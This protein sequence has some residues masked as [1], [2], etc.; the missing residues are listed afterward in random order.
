[1]ANYNGW[2]N[3][4]TWCVA[5]WLDNDEGTQC[6][7]QEWADEVKSEHPLPEPT[8]S[9]RKGASAAYRQ[10]VEAAKSEAAVGLADRL[11]DFV[12]EQAPDLGASMFADL[13]G[14]AL[15]EVDWYEIAQ[16]ALEE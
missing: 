2:T 9:K 14:A 11:K 1:M 4:E 10:A 5:L 6:M 13:L 16:N 8:K 7:V 3:Y 12:E 15:G